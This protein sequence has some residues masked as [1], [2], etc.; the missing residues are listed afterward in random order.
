MLS[1]YEPTNQPYHQPV[2]M[3]PTDAFAPPTPT[4]GTPPLISLRVLFWATPF[5]ILALFVWPPDRSRAQGE[6]ITPTP[7]D[8]GTLPVA[9]H[10]YLPVVANQVP[11]TPTPPPTPT[12]VFTLIPVVPPPVDRPAATN[13]DLNLA[14]RGYAPITAALALIDVGGD[15]DPN[16]PQLAAIF[17][18]P[19]LPTLMRTYQVYDWNWACGVDGCRG[20]PLGNPEVTL[21]AV[22]TTPGEAL[23]I[24]SRIPEIHGG[25]FRALVLYATAAQITLAYTRQDTAAVGYLVHLAGIA[26]DPALVAL[27][28]AQ[29][30]TGRASLPALHNN[31]RLGRALTDTLLIAIRDTGSFM[32]P[33]SRKDWWVGYLTR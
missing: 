18:P 28:E 20:Q 22:A 14:I 11:P 12:T 3:K 26:V 19:R 15:T 23:Y 29:N 9:T 21:I 10:V 6:T 24:P 31:E 17:D 27:Y 25:G 16:A 5:L 2:T 32:D 30:A 4:T 1:Y 13:P 7:I 33:R 8:Q